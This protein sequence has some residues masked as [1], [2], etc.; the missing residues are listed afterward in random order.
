MIQYI[1]T[2]LYSVKIVRT[3]LKRWHKMTIDGK[4]RQEEMEFKV[5]FKGGL[6]IDR[7]NVYR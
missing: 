4:G 3:N 2:N 6:G 7:T 5:A 1:H